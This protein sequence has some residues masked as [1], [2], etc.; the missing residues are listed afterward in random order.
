MSEEELARYIQNLREELARRKTQS[1]IARDLEN[2]V[3]RLVA[4]NPDI[5]ATTFS[6][7]RLTVAAGA[8]TVALPEAGTDDARQLQ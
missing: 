7:G 1:A 6:E 3:D 8:V 4:T 2:T 5:M